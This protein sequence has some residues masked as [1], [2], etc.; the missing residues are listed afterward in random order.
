MARKSIIVILSL[1]AIA[2]LGWAQTGPHSMS[3]GSGAGSL[4]FT[5]VYSWGHIDG[6][7][8]T[9]IYSASQSSTTIW[10]LCWFIYDKTNSQYYFL[11]KDFTSSAHTDHRPT[12]GTVDTSQLPTKLSNTGMGFPNSSGLTADLTMELTQPDPGNTARLTYT[13][14]FN[15][16]GSSAYDVRMILFV[17]NDCYFDGT[18]YNDDIVARTSSEFNPDW[19]V[20]GAGENNGSGLVD[21][22]RGIKVDCDMQV[23]SF[24]GISDDMGS[25]YYWSSQYTFAGKAPEDVM[26]I[27]SDF[28]NTIQNDADSNFLS[29]SGKDTG[30]ALQVDFAVPASG[31]YTVH[32]YLTWGLDETL[33]GGLLSVDSWYLY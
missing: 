21:L 31:S 24:F 14:T 25:S 9:F 29:D 22:N 28:A 15:N 13:W 19:P 20:L 7:D 11:D 10:N 17:D 3:I 27:H 4:S 30:M 2:S 6:D 18:N 16:S 33:D 8:G 32:F 26:E 12:D 23:T 1:L 5:K